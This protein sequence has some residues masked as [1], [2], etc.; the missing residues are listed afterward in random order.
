[1]A[2]KNACSSWTWFTTFCEKMALTRGYRS[3]KVT[4]RTSRT[5][6]LFTM[7]TGDWKKRSTCLPGRRGIGHQYASFLSR[8][9]QIYRNRSGANA[10]RFR[11]THGQSCNRARLAIFL[12]AIALLDLR[13][14]FRKQNI[15]EPRQVPPGQIFV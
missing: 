13:L 11:T 9:T 15:R 2:T 10:A 4:R 5:R 7:E 14:H 6:S 8:L 1:M 12:R 3:G